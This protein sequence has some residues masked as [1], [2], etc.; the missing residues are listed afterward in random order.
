MSEKEVK[1]CLLC[2]VG[3]QGTVLASRI[4]AAAAMAKGLHARTAETIGMAQRGG[5][6]V[7]HVRIGE[8][9]ASPMIPWGRA[10]VI[11]GFEPGEAAAN[12][13]YLKESGVLILSSRQ[14]KPVTAALG[15]SGYEGGDCLDWLKS[16]GSRCVVVDPDEI[17]EACGSPKVL[18]VAMAGALAATGAM[19][20][21]IEDM[22]EALKIRMK[23]KL[24]EMNM[25]A[26]HMGADCVKER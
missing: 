7:S 8:D 1:S 17:I 9:I 4:I 6:V 13:K 24:L 14:V 5:S 19:D 22:E 2:G 3:G 25:K 20:L 26:L 10:D 12:I 21:T 18:N 11:I 16:K 15:Q 23:P